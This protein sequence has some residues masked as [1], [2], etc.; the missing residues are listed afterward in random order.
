MTL[1]VG[2]QASAELIG[3]TRLLIR[4]RSSSFF[5]GGIAAS[6]TATVIALLVEY[7]KPCALMLSN[8]SAVLAVPCTLIQRSMICAQLLFAN[9]K[10]DLKIEQIFGLR[11]I[12]IAQILRN[13][14]VERSSG[15]PWCRS[16]GDDFRHRSPECMR[17]LILRV[18]ARAPCV[19]S[20]QRLVHIAEHFAL[21]LFPVLLQGKIV[22]TQNHILRRNGYRTSVGRFQAG[23]W[24]PASGNGPLPGPQ[25]TAARE[26][27]SGRRQSRRYKRYKPGDAASRHG[28]LPKQAQRPEYPV[29][30]GWEH[31]STAPDAP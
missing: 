29:Y 20:H 15:P 4:L 7:L 19:I 3:I 28:L 12:H 18:Q 31:G 13:R 14:L 17:T 22:G 2:D 6:Q 8:T 21:A 23:C 11:T 30:A 27:P 10:V 25:R 5:C 26:Q 16:I 24:P 1:L 9:H